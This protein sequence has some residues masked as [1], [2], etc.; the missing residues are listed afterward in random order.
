[1]PC[2]ELDLDVNTALIF[3]WLTTDARYT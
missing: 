1:M 3:G 2:Y